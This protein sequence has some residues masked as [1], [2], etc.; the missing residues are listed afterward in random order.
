MEENTQTNIQDLPPEWGDSRERDLSEKLETMEYILGFKR[1]R[2]RFRTVII[3]DIVNLITYLTKDT[4][5][6]EH[7]ILYFRKC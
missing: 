4:E 5:I 7:L 2:W 6:D 3:S 1:N